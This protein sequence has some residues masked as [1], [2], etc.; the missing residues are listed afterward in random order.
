[1]TNILYKFQQL[2]NLNKSLTCLID[3][4]EIMAVNAS[5]Q[6]ERTS[7][8]GTNLYLLEKE[9]IKFSTQNA[10]LSK[11]IDF[12][13]DETS[14]FLNGKI[15]DLILFNKLI[16]QSIDNYSF[17]IHKNNL[18]NNLKRIDLLN[19]KLENDTNSLNNKSKQ[20]SKILQ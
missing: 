20:L 16:K 1:M 5:V 14:K 12:V 8:N 19:I 4:A 17:N 18:S 6:K 7:E 10:I 11:E 9:L 3:D 15:N 13:T 2:E